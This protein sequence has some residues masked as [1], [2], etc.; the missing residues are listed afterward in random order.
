MLPARRLRDNGGR[1][2][3]SK[4][5]ERIRL[6][7]ERLARLIAQSRMS[8]N[9][10]A[11]RLGVGRGHLSLL[12]RGKRPY[13]SPE[14]R[15]KLLQGLGRRFEELFVVEGRA[16]TAGST[17]LGAA[18]AA[19]KTSASNFPKKGGEPMLHA[20]G[21]DLRF[22]FRMLAKTPGFTAVAVLALALGI[23]ANALLFSIVDATLLRPLPFRDADRLA[24]V[25]E[26]AVA[27]NRDRNVVA[28]ANFM[29]WRERNEVFEDMAAFVPWEVNL[30]GIGDPERIKAGL[31]TSNLFQ[32]LGVDA[33]LGRAL[34][35]ADDA[36]GAEAV[37]TLSHGFWLR[38]FGGDRGALGKTISLNDET[39]KIVGV[40][41]P[42][43]DFPP[44]VELWTPYRMRESFRKHYGRYLAV[45]ARLKDGIELPAA[46]ARMAALADSLRTENPDELAGW[47]V[48]AISLREQLVGEFRPALL[49]LLGAVVFVLLI[50]CANVANLLLARSAIRER[51]LALRA[52]LGA[53]RARLVRQ[54]LTESATLAALGGAIGLVI[55]RLGLAVLPALIPAELPDFLQIRLDAPVVLFTLGVSLLT[56]LV[57]G[58]APAFLASRSD[59]GDTLKEGGRSLVGRRPAFSGLLVAGE[60]AFAL[61]LLVG[62]GLLLRSFW[63]L[64]KTDP[65]FNPEDLLAVQISL[66]PSRYETGPSQVRFFEE[67]VER[68]SSMPGVEAAGAVSWLPLAGPGSA[69]SIWDAG[70]PKPEAGLAPVADI[71]VITPGL[72]QAMQIRI[73][74]GRDLDGRDTAESPP[75]VVVNRSMAE[76]MWPDQNPVGKR[77]VMSWDTERVAEVVGVVEDVRLTRLDTQARH[78]L[79]WPMS[80][81]PNDFMSILIRSQA[82]PGQLAPAIRSEIRAIDP[83]QPI[84][85]IRPMES[86]VSDSVKKA[87]FTAVLLGTF[88]ALAFILAAVGI[89]G[90]VSYS[91]TQRT[92]E[93][94]VRMAFG[95]GRGDIMKM[96]LREGLARTT[97]GLAAG[98][99]LSF[100][101]TR[102]LG[103]LLYGV[104][105]TDPW[106]FGAAVVLLAL[107][108]LTATWI[109][110]RRATAVDP[111]RTLRYE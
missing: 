77:V 16:D 11:R 44:G 17:R 24:M 18:P 42:G 63:T 36:E 12:V 84:S 107:V 105:A 108:A 46:H 72:F 79:Y 109:P 73:L 43:F 90:V 62:A 15:L 48:N 57:F 37:A 70:R 53:G 41:P 32:I 55:A 106:A 49:T 19:E 68:L 101:L 38:R 35:P 58:S 82:K 98:V 91:V 94:G 95:A 14:T 81:L 104:A 87:R 20:L 29:A 100:A 51:E 28:P 2:R 6:R 1:G 26:H 71:R 8:Q 34:E 89:Y 22:A 102:F 56:A 93:I 74:Q 80:Q 86:I 33:L 61:V 60:V 23:G 13:P 4:M 50:G 52:A 31:T 111:M 21:Q 64:V 78:T 96:V 27:R 75:S 66:P 103:S 45:V 92:Q 5:A 3:G 99:A 65:G 54:M 40:M 30:T 88:A 7:H 69:T 59:P 9:W 39:L 47:S 76:E 83:D 85:A 25:W 110:A 10:W 97:L 67:A